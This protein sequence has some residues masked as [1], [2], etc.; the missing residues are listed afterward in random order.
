MKLLQAGTCV[1]QVFRVPIKTKRSDQSLPFCGFLLQFF[2]LS[3]CMY[4]RHYLRL[5]LAAD[6]RHMSSSFS[7]EA[8][9][10]W[11]RE[12]RFTSSSSLYFKLKLPEE[13]FLHSCLAPGPM[14]CVDN[15]KRSLKTCIKVLFSKPVLLFD[16]IADSVVECSSLIRVF[17]KH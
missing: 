13:N 11:F 12:S 1:L 16:R 4:C 6:I 5:K 15:T 9:I 8:E 7:S 10:H 14:I 3:Y 2:L 17:L